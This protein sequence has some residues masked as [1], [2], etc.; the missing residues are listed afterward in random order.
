[1][2]LICTK[3]DYAGEFGYPIVSLITD[4]IKVKFRERMEELKKFGV[5][6]S[7]QREYYFGTNESLELSY[8]EI[9]EMVDNAK[10]IT[11]ME[12]EVL[13]KFNILSLGINIVSRAMDNE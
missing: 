9:I 4:E 6:F 7:D 3:R 1:M 11:D 10:P 8:N 13:T 2:K 5:S 12:L